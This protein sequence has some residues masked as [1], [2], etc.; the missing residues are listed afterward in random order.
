MNSPATPRWCAIDFGTSNSAVALP[1]ADGVALAPVEGDARL[2]PTAVFYEVPESGVRSQALKSP[3]PLF[4]RAAM[5]AYI[6]GHEGRLMRSMKSILGSTLADAQTDIGGGLSRAYTDIVGDFVRH[7][8]S[9][10]EAAAGAPLQR[11]LIGR[12]VYFVDD[13][14]ERDA[15]AQATLEAIARACG[16]DEVRFAYEPLAAAHDLDNQLRRDGAHEALALIADFGGGTCDFSLATL[17]GDA[18][19]QIHGHH[20]IHIAGTDFDRH[21]SLHALMPLLGHRSTTR[22]GREMPSRIFHDLSTWH[23]VNGCYAAPVVA[24]WQRARADFERPEVHNRLMRVLEERL[25]HQ[26]VATAEHIKVNAAENGQ[27][28]ADL[29]HIEADLHREWD[30]QQMARA[31]QDDIERI[32]NAAAETLRRAG[33]AQNQVQLVYFTGGSSRLKLLANAVMTRT[34]QAR[35]VWGDSFASVAQGLGQMARG[36]LTQRLK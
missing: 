22:A 24:Q 21:V 23:L 12:P 18:D 17:G 9:S 14:P 36:L 15:R 2:L 16:F 10:A 34:P 1:T 30:A 25:G 28:T 6:A 26:L 4:G 13:D 29:S 27:A 11:A 8:K 7:L 20:G 31:L 35:P 3:Q 5:D 19:A 33:I 32:A